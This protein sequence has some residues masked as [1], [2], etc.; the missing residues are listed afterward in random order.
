[1]DPS[2]QSSGDLDATAPSAPM[3]V[4]SLHTPGYAE[5]LAVGERF[6]VHVVYNR[7]YFLPETQV[8]E[9]R[10]RVVDVTNPSASVVVGAANMSSGGA[11]AVAVSGTYD[12]VVGTSCG[13]RGCSSHLW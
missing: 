2:V 9:S 11:H 3:E 5:S 4:G 12:Y 1:M 6:F 8:D 13:P 7:I 10:L